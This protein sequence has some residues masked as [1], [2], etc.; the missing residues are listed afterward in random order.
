MKYP[1]TLYSTPDDWGQETEMATETVMNRTIRQLRKLGEE[2]ENIGLSDCWEWSLVEISDRPGGGAIYEA[3][4][5][6]DGGFI[7]ARPAGRGRYNEI[8]SGRSLEDL[9]EDLAG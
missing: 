5:S 3:W 6:R 7:L 9:K 4:G 2:W 8:A 1:N